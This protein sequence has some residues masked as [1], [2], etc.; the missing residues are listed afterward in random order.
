MM[1]GRRKLV[2]LGDGMVRGRSEEQEYQNE[3]P[4]VRSNGVSEGMK[5]EVSLEQ[6]MR[7]DWG[8]RL[9]PWLRDMA[10]LVMTNC[11]DLI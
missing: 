9:G 2:S 7:R 4:Q 5:K 3:D 8:S 6:D 11:L 10:L 1:E